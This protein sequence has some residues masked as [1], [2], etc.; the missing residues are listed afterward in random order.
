MTSTLVQKGTIKKGATAM[1]YV[2]Y[3]V[4]FVLL[5]VL[6]V[7]VDTF[8]AAVSSGSGVWLLRGLI[9]LSLVVGLIGVVV[10]SAWARWL[11][12]LCAAGYIPAVFGSLYLLAL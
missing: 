2:P 6:L 5:G 9:L 10:Q 7:D 8:A 4:Y 12:L 3:V 11:K 1:A